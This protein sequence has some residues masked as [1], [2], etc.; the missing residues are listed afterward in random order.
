MQ[1]GQPLAG[2]AKDLKGNWSEAGAAMPLTS[3][4][5][6]KSGPENLKATGS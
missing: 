6:L 2:E 4:E 5:A 1:P 3:K